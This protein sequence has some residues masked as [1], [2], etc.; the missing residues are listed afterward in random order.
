MIDLYSDTLTKPSKEMRRAMAEAEVGDEQRREDPSTN[1]LQAMVAE[2]LG[3]EAAVFLPSGAMCN[4]VAI[5]TH[6]Q[7]GDA[8]LCERY[9]HVYR[10]EFGAA[11]VLSGVT[12]EPID[13]KRGI[14]T[15]EQ[16]GA[17]IATFGAYGATPRVLCVEQT[18]NYGAGAIWPIQGLNE[19]C[20]VA[21]SRGLKTHMDG[22]RL[23]NAAVATGVPARDF[24][25]NFD[26]VW[27]DLSKGLGCPVGAVL[28]GSKEFIDRAWRWKHA[29]GGAMRQSGILAAAGC[30]ALQHNIKRLAD[31]HANARSLADGLASIKGIR[32]DGWMP[33]T[34]IVFF[35]TTDAGVAPQDFVAKLLQHGVRMG[36]IS[37]RVR[38]VTH[39]DI[40][41]EDVHRAVDVIREVL[42]KGPTKTGA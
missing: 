33:Q 6:T 30:Y 35:D 17:A 39:L 20:E 18:H 37:R 12:T 8:I 31:D 9:A 25:R 2:L 4:A 23:F 29:F 14:F 36:F 22:A 32:V 27:I 21:H 3:K 34:N 41:R 28:A 10:S 11:A 13:G 15:A 19:V 7:A 26:S 16:V 5:K 1:A 40:M 42:S 24:A 38:A